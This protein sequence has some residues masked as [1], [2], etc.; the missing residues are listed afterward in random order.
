MMY[1]VPH[2][3]RLAEYDLPENPVASPGPLQTLSVLKKVGSFLFGFGLLAAA[4]HYLGIGPEVPE[5][6]TAG[7]EGEAA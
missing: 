5:E 1:V 3:D 4:L 7:R 6:E 2:G